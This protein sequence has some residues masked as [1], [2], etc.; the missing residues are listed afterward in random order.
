MLNPLHIRYRLNQH[1]SSSWRLVIDLR[2]NVVYTRRRYG[3]LYEI[4]RIVSTDR[5]LQGICDLILVFD[6]LL[7]LAYWQGVCSECRLHFV[8][9]GGY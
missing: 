6:Y 4:A 9:Y 8:S 5:A 7:V 1:R 2:E 3:T